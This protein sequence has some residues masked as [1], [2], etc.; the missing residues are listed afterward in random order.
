MM[1]S[2]IEGSKVKPLTPLPT[3]YFHIISIMK[4]KMKIIQELTKIISQ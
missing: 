2:P 4:G 3:D 1:N